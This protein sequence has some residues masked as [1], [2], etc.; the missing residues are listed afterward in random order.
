[1]T[2]N[3]LD[4]RGTAS[5]FADWVFQKTNPRYRRIEHVSTI[6]DRQALGRFAHEQ[7][8]S[9]QFWLKSIESARGISSN[10]KLVYADPHD[11]A[12]KHIF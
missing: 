2:E 9:F 10:W 5:H 4:Y 7:I 8:E 6:T 11:G 3:E 12:E 1:M